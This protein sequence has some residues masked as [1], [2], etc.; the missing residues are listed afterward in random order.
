MLLRFCVVF[1]INPAKWA[2]KSKTPYFIFV[3]KINFPPISISFSRIKISMTCVQ[4][5][6]RR[7]DFRLGPWGKR[8]RIPN[9]SLRLQATTSQNSVFKQSFRCGTFCARFKSWRHGFLI[10]GCRVRCVCFSSDLFDFLLF[11]EQKSKSGS[12]RKQYK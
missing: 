2:N 9:G 3:F 11:E 7:A 12:N 10:S 4:K 1:F 5:T 8:S 6:T